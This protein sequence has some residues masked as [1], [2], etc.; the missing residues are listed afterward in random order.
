MREGLDV[1]HLHVHVHVHVC[2]CVSFSVSV[3]VSDSISIF[4]FLCST[5]IISSGH[6]SA[7]FSMVTCT[8][9][10]IAHVKKDKH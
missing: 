4:L 5:N 6:F 8:L 3:A 10:L 7:F 1:V 9:W 2:V